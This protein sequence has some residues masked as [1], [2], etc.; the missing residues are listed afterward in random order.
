MKKNIQKTKKRSKQEAAQRWAGYAKA[1]GLGAFALG[2]AGH[3]DAKV[4]TH[5]ILHNGSPL[6]PGVMINP[7]IYAYH[8]TFDIDA[9]GTIDFMLGTGN[10]GSAF[11]YDN[12]LGGLVLTS[13][14]PASY[15]EAFVAGAPIDG[16]AAHAGHFF[17]VDTLNPAGTFGAGQTG[18]MGF[19]TSLGYFG[20]MSLTLTDV[21]DQ[22]FN[23]VNDLKITIN[24]A[25]YE[26]TG[27]AIPAG[28]TPEPSS[29]ALLAAGS[30]GLLA[31]RRRRSN[32][33]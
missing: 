1:A 25:G 24:G 23:G 31:R 19:Q 28:A 2:V 8:N 29:L 21:G 22:G 14:N 13:G 20:W 16:S 17:G 15:A 6:I 10:Y 3:A 32:A 11:G 18:L 5:G 33:A 26:N 30:I 7:P 27:A 9:D 12:T 4:V